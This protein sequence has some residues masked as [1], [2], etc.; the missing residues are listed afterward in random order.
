MKILYNFQILH[1]VFNKHLISSL[2]IVLLLS[3]QLFAQGNGTI[4][5]HITDE[6]TGEVLIRVNVLISG[7]TIGAASDLDGNYTITNVPAGTYSLVFSLI[8]YQ[9]I[10]K[11]D[12]VVNADQTVK[13]DVELATSAIELGNVTVYGASRRNEKI[14]EAPSAVSVIGVELTLRKVV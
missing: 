4:N 3:C 14:T 11:D 1:V 9:T 13:L 5:G 12:V 6:S 7:T 2:A 10:T 8:S